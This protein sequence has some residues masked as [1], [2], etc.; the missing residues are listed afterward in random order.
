MKL[1]FASNNK[2][3][4]EEIKAILP[5]SIELLTLEDVHFTEDIEETGETLEANAA[6]KA[7][8]IFNATGLACFADDSG[9]LVEAL[10][11]RPGV[12]SA[13]F[14]GEPVNHEANIA[15]LLKEL[16]GK[17]NRNAAFKTVICYKDSDNELFFEGEAKGRII[18]EKKGLNGFG[19]D[20]VFIPENNTR[21]FAEMSLEE[22]NK[23][24]HR[25]RA[26]AKM[27]DYF[28]KQ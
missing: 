13:R 1:V 16:N 4:F 20:P 6:L 26:F 2:N 10:N 19:Y 5:E 25:K 14:A 7:N 12:K 3:K 28:N 8:T 17:T 23:I 21:T 15:L 18:N 22:K 9:L 24:S 27:V 11:G